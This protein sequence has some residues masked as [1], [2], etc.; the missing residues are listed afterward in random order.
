MTPESHQQPK[1]LAARRKNA[2]VMMGDPDGHPR[3]YHIYQY[4]SPMV[5]ERT[6]GDLEFERAL[7]VI[8]DVP[9]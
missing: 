6:H 2:S 7:S 5:G 3:V 9:R 8:K 4:L 1:L